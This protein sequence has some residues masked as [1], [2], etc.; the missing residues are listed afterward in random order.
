[1]ERLEFKE[2]VSP[3]LTTLIGDDTIT[4]EEL[5]NIFVKHDDQMVNYI[6]EAVSLR[7]HLNQRLRVLEKQH[8]ALKDSLMD[9]TEKRLIKEIDRREFP[10]NLSN[11]RRKVNVLEVNI[12]KCKDLFKD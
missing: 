6:D 3:E 10:E 8:L 12:K 11:H 5:Y 7:E 2:R 9:L 1:L 4:D